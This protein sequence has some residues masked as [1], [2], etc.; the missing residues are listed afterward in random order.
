MGCKH[1]ESK[2]HS[3]EQP[4]VVANKPVKTE[5]QKKETQEV[6]GDVPEKKEEH[7]GLWD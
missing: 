6:T 2:K 5:P 7:K 3:N 1:V 4:D